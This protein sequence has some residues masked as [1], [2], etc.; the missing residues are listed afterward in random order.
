MILMGG[1]GLTPAYLIPSQATTAAINL[2]RDVEV[3]GDR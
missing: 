2:A 1:N 3:P